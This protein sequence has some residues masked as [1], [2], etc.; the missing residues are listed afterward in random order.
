MYRSISR[1]KNLIATCLELSILFP[2][3][4]FENLF[5]DLVK[6]V[7]CQNNKDFNKRDVYV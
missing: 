7:D 1:K 3:Q 2:V 6:F 5:L 4:I